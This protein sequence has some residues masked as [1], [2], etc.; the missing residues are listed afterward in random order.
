MVIINKGEVLLSY[1]QYLTLK[2]LEKF[3]Y[4]SEAM[5]YSD[6]TFSHISM[7]CDFFLKL[8]L[9]EIGKT[10]GNKKEILLTSKGK[11]VLELYIR[12]YNLLNKK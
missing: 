3:H 2:G 6:I 12:V 5:R 9:I 4:M 11:E 7:V 10:F 1:K 8:K